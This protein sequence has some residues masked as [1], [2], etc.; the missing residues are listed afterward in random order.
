MKAI[1]PHDGW[2]ILLLLSGAYFASIGNN[3]CLAQSQFRELI[4]LNDGDTLLGDVDLVSAEAELLSFDIDEVIVVTEESERQLLNGSDCGRIQFNF[5]N[6][7]LTLVRKTIVN[8]GFKET[9]KLIR[10]VVEGRLQ[11]YEYREPLPTR[12]QNKDAAYAGVFKNYESLYFVQNDSIP[13]ESVDPKKIK[14]RLPDMMRDDEDLVELIQLKI[15]NYD[16]I[17][18]TVRLYNGL[19][20]STIDESKFLAGHVDLIYGNRVHCKLELLDENL[21]CQILSIIDDNGKPIHIRNDQV[22]SYRRAHE[23]FVARRIAPKKRK[24]VS[25]QVFMKVLVDGEVSLYE[26]KYLAANRQS[27]LFNDNQYGNWWSRWNHHSFPHQPINHTFPSYWPSPT[28]YFI[29]T[30]PTA[31]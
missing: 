27:F 14:T 5:K 10:A 23:L 7:P 3:Y 16:L 18:E 28:G 8:E 2:L 1:L 6:E 11:L 17:E 31:E 12:K 19:P 26:Y 25:K 4:V 22:N 20:T 24:E 9:S 29:R 21:S 30:S 13:L 15:I